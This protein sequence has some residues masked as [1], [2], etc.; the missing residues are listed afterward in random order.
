MYRERA[1][2]L[3]EVYLVTVDD[4]AGLLVDISENQGESITGFHEEQ[5]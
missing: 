3:S 4:V 5:V 1:N 2:Q